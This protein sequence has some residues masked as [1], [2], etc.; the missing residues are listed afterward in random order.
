MFSSILVISFCIITVISLLLSKH[1]VVQTRD[2]LLNST[3]S[4]IR[5]QDAAED[6]IEIIEAVS[7]FADIL[8]N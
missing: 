3:D 4:Y 1:T 8:F 7:F 6:L 2:I 5:G